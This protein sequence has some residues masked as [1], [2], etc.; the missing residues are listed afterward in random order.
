MT[1]S[2]G[3]LYIVA[4]PIGNLEDLSPRARRV[5]AE[6]SLIAVEDTRHTGRLLSRIGVETATIS[7]HDHNEQSRV[8]GL[9]ERLLGGD[10]I[11]LVSDAGTPLVSDPGYRLVA[12]AR[13]AGIT[14]QAV[15]GPSAATAAISIAGLPSDR[16]VFEG[17]LPRQ[18]SDLQARLALLAHEP[19][20]S[21]VFIPVHRLQ[22]TLEALVDTLGSSRP[23]L[24]A[25]ELTKL[26]EESCRG[27]LGELA[28]L[29]Q[30]GQFSRGELVLVI[31]GVEQQQITPANAEIRRVYGELSAELPPKQALALTVRLTGARR[32]DVYAMV[33]VDEQA[34]KDPEEPVT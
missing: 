16:W 34:S 9:L 30:Q 14:V 20:T 13:G 3:S 10:D 25:R 1:Q 2:P 32:R 8:Q 29:C 23:A 18:A 33:H 22:A 5:L 26:H 24:L 28:S 7:Y 27:T 17:F 21:V 12:A 15:P 4:T 19:R 11:A 31:G 6:V